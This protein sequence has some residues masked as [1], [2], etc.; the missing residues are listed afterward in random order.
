[1]YAMVLNKPRS[2]L[3]LVERPDPRPA[4]GQ[5]LLEVLACGVCRTDLH[6]LDGELPDAELPVVPGHQVVGRV[7][8]VNGRLP[9][10]VEQRVG[11]A[12]LGAHCGDCGYCR[13]GNENL[14]DSARFTGYQ[15]DGGYA[16]QIVADAAH[17]YPL[18]ETLDDV[19]V[20]PLLCA[21]VIGYR[22]L[23]MAG[24]APRLGLYGFG[25]AGHINLQVAKAQG[26][27]VFAFT[28]PGDTGGQDFARRL[29]AD[30]A[31]GSD[32]LPPEPLDAAIIFAPAGELVPQ[33][34]QAVRKGGSVVCGGI[35]MSDIPGFAYRLL[36]GERRLVSVANMTC[37]DAREFLQLAGKLRLQPE[38]T[39]FPLNGANRALEA[40]RAGQL[41]GAAVLDMRL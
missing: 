33:A 22:C 32:T 17:C 39:A 40:L 41:N 3:R 19:H 16:T 26:R 34:L 23:R 13:Q 7:L 27:E 29:G 31:G 35:H 28:R 30:W 21:G 18:P 12:W 14:C 9:F 2:P 6:L 24:E 37:A 8:E 15:L 38:V 25:A 1:M 36:W 5:L 4:P 20:A 10:S 11:V